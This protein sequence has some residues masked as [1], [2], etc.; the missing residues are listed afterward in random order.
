MLPRLSPKWPIGQGGQTKGENKY[1]VVDTDNFC[2]DFCHDML[3]V[4]REWMRYGIGCGLGL[5][6]V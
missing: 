6:E 1:A 2:H 5:D 3:L 4:V